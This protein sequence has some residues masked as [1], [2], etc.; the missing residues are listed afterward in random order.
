MTYRNIL[1]PVTG[2]AECGPA[3]DAAL[4]LASRFD[5]HLVGL[6]VKVSSLEKLSFFDEGLAQPKD[7]SRQLA[8]LRRNI[9]YSEE[10]ARTQFEARRRQVD[11]PVEEEPL[12]Q[13]RATAS[14][15]V[16]ARRSE[17]TLAEVAR[18]YDLVVMPAVGT[19]AGDEALQAVV[20]VLF[21]SGRPVLVIPK[22]VPEA[23][24]TNLFVSWNRSAQSA[25]A[26]AAAAAFIEAASR[27]TVAY[28]NTGAK[29]GPTLEEVVASLAWRGVAANAQ[30]INP[31]GE[32]V[33]QLL[34][35]HAESAGADLMVMGA[36]S[37]SRLRDFVLGGVTQQI[38]R[39]V[40]LPIL[41]MH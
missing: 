4:Q 1:V 31:Q 22:D 39:N 34:V 28:V 6:H 33:A 21:G 24:G 23:L 18:I 3:I 14:F 37:H 38:L 13:A 20:G 26:V 41:M 11:M 12:E 30:R 2:D 19:V 7:I 15:Q 36:Y 9:S 29:A 17:T 32:S 16:I 8:N 25:R 40:T 27:V 5:A 35:S 10:A